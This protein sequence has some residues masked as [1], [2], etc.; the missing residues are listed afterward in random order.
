MALSFQKPTAKKLT[1]PKKQEVF[2]K[3]VK[4]T[5]KI[6]APDSCVDDAARYDAQIKDL[7]EALAAQNQ[8]FDEAMAKITEL[9]QDVPAGSK[10]IIA[11]MMANVTLGPK[12]KSTKVTASMKEIHEKLGDEVFYSLC[13]VGITDLKKYL[14]PEEL[15]DATEVIQEGARSK[16]FIE[17]A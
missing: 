14:T 16:K 11:G 15:D 1:K 17:K 8:N 2:G 4:G 6:E 10:V 5:V 13:K 12:G 9:V 7:K 3:E